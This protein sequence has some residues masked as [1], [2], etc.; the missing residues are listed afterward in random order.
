[1]ARVLKPHWLSK[2]LAGL[3]LG[4]WLALG[5]ASL[6]ALMGPGE[7]AD[8]YKAQFVMWLMAPVWLLVLSLVYLFPTG[9][10]AWF[11]LGLACLL[12][13]LVFWCLK[14]AL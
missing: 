12:V 11:W 2:T 3:L 1:M 6:V 13:T 4:Y 10:R 7:L 5:L 14:G 8:P 9:L